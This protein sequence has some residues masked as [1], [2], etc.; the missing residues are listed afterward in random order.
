MEKLIIY[1][2]R[3]ISSKWNEISKSW[4]EE[5]IAKQEGDII[6]Y[7]NRIVEIQPDVTVEDFMNHLREYEAAIDYCFSDY[8]KGAKLKLFLDDMES[9]SIEKNDLVEVELSWEGEIIGDDMVIIG[10]LRAWLTNEKIKELGE[11]YEVPHDVS[12]ASMST[13]KKCKF[14]LNENIS[15]INVDQQDFSKRE[16]VFDGFYRWTLF[17]VISNFLMELSANGAPSERDD[18]YLQMKN[19]KFD[20]K[21]VAKDEDKKQF[22]LTFLTDELKRLKDL[23]EEV[24]ENEDY[25]TASELKVEVGILEKELEKL[26]KEIKRLH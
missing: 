11:E 17:E 13:W 5:D 9:E 23:K 24:L 2:D 21:E 15:V 16:I 22:W 3:I 6:K 26:K 20:V 18:L 8:T 19:K 4:R 10:Y 14:N 1:K 7:L 12:F 25:E